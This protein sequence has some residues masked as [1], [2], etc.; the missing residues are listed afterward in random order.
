MD[1]DFLQNDLVFLDLEATGPNFLRDR[2]M[3]LAMIKCKP[4][5]SILEWNQYINPG[6]PIT[7]EAYAIHKI[8]S[9]MI[10]RKPTFLQLAD[11]IHS[12]IG[13]ADLAAYNSYKLDIPLL[14]E[15]FNRAGKTWDITSRKIIDVQRIFHKMEPRTL[16]AAL[17]FYCGKEMESAHDALADTKAIVEI[18]KGQIQKYENQNLIDEEGKEYPAPVQRNIESL[19]QFTNDQN[20]VDV[21]HRLK[22]NAEG[23]MVFNFG[24]YV[25]QPVID[26]FKRDRNFYHWIQ[27]KEFSIQVKSILKKVF[28]ENIDP[29]V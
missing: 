27:N 17:K 11:E 16:K 26:V 20:M 22:Y 4:D 12:F 28:Q 23:A 3:Q 18:F 1:L 2:I 5:G 19:H 8:D 13:K 7:E 10:A 21:T 6:V 24:K 9:S 25:G 14:M 29:K 15:E